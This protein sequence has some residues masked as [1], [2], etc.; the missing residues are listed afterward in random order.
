MADKYIYA[1]ARI[2]SKE[3]SLLSGAFLEQLTAAKSYDQCI[4]LLH[5]KGWGGDG[6]TNPEELLAAEREKTWGLISELVEDRSVFDVFLY[7]ND[8]HNLKA[9]IKEI[10]MGHQ[11]PGIFISQ[12]TLDVKRIRDSI[13]NREFQNLPEA[14]RG[15]AKEA[16]RALLHTQDGQLCDIIIDKAALEAIYRA[17]KESGNEFLK[18]YAE[19]TVAA[20]DI[21]TAVRA[22]RTGKD[23]AFLKQAL[24]PCD[25][26]DIYRLA[27]AAIEGEDAIGLY[28]EST[29]YADAV[30]E[31]RRS[32]SAFERWCDNLMIRRMKPQ[33]YVPFGLGPLAAYIL[34][35]ENEVKSV[36][37][38][39]SGKLN[40]LP[41]ESIRER[42]REMYV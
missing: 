20:A 32:P 24:A 28:L 29:P 33:Q 16:Y 40:H 26:L 25:T 8:Y 39:L 13:Q 9:A 14:M 27:Q 31:L 21:K 41:E 3:L 22:S 18:L 7:A 38:V 30:E 17:G 15:P 11:F 19:L 12:G 6:I 1:V 42:V 36:R 37:I 5:E 2:R 23:R 10:R 35:R 4:Q 34:A